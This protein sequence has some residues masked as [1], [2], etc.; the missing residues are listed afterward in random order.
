MYPIKYQKKTC[1]LSLVE[2]YLVSNLIK[3]FPL[4]IK[5]GSCIFNCENLAQQV[6]SWGPSMEIF[7]INGA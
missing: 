1:G 3:D 7:V 4:L 2:G 6:Y 5:C